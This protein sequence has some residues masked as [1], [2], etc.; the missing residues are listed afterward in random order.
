[1][2]SSQVVDDMTLER[3]QKQTEDIMDIEIEKSD[4]ACGINY[5]QCLVPKG[6]DIA[7]Y[8]L[9]KESWPRE[10]K[11]I[12]A[13]YDDRSVIVYQA[14]KPAIAKYAVQNQQFGGPDFSYERMS[15]V[16]T[17]FLWMM[18]RCGWASK[19]NQQRVLAV[20]IS[21]HGFEKILANAFTVK[22]Q[23]EENVQTDEISVRL[24]WDPD[25]SPT[26]DKLARKAI[27]LGLKGEILKTYGTE[28]IQSITDITDFVKSQKKILDREGQKELMTPKER[29]YNVLDYNTCSRIDLD[30]FEEGES[31]NYG[32]HGIVNY[33]KNVED[34]AQTKPM[35]APSNILCVLGLGYEVE[36]K[37]LQEMF[38]KYGPIERVNIVCDKKTGKSRGY[39]FVE[40]KTLEDAVK[41]KEHL[42]GGHIE[43]IEIKVEF[44]QSK[45]NSKGQDSQGSGTSKPNH[46]KCQVSGCGNFNFP[47]RK[48]C[49]K[50]NAPRTKGHNESNT[51]DG[52]VPD[53][54]AEQCVRNAGTAEQPG[55]EDISGYGKGGRFTVPEDLHIPQGMEVPDTQ[56]QH[57]AIEKTAKFV[58]ANGIQME[59]MIKSKQGNNPKLTFLNLHDPLNFYY[60]HM[61]KMIKAGKYTPTDQTK[62]DDSIGNEIPQNTS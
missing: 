23:R 58:A 9:Q 36:N 12:L 10:G 37:H 49:S 31:R 21:R 55:K 41:A 3:N 59:I 52:G 18:Y 44:S 43:D 11:H 51:Q 15:W 2:A 25:H 13:Q 35:P 42:H 32:I 39:A 62:G 8:I 30:V 54:A 53:F 5:S 16:K 45:S 56:E 33:Y 46:W 60:N 27:Q 28:W 14:F 19:N 57:L 34:A 22:F 1:M 20:R 38:G 7:K 40:Y 17:N 6:I 4:M 24:Q 50:C 29:V 48:R 47:V 26:Y 61:V